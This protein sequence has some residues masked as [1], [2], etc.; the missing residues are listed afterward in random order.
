MAA[1]KKTENSPTEPAPEF[2]KK[3]MFGE[4]S[5]SFSF[6][7]H[8]QGSL[9]SGFSAKVKAPSGTIKSAQLGGDGEG[10]IAIKYTPTEAGM[11]LLELFHAGMTI[12]KPHPFKSS[13]GVLMPP[14]WATLTQDEK[15]SVLRWIARRLDAHDFDGVVV[16]DATSSTLLIASTDTNSTRPPESDE[17][18]L[19]LIGVVAEG[20][21]EQFEALRTKIIAA[22]SDA[23]FYVV[24]SQG[25]IQDGLDICERLQGNYT[26]SHNLRAHFQPSI[27]LDGRPRTTVTIPSSGSLAEAATDARRAVAAKVGHRTGAM[28]HLEIA[29]IA[30]RWMHARCQKLPQLVSGVQLEGFGPAS[31]R[32]ALVDGMANTT[33]IEGSALTLD[34]VLWYTSKAQGELHMRRRAVQAVDEPPVVQIEREAIITT[35]YQVGRMQQV[36]WL[37][38]VEAFFKSSVPKGLSALLSD[39]TQPDKKMAHR[40]RTHD[41]RRGQ[42]QLAQRPRIDF[43]PSFLSDAEVDHLLH[44]GLLH[45]KPSDSNSDDNELTHGGGAIVQFQPS[46]AT[47]DAIVQAVEERIAEATGVPVHDGE[48]AL[49]MRHN[50]PIKSNGPVVDSVHLDTN[51]DK[52][53]RCATVI[54]YLNDVPEGCGGETRFPLADLPEE[55]PLVAAAVEAATIGL[56]AIKSDVQNMPAHFAMLQEAACKDECPVKCAHSAAPPLPFG[57][58]P[59]RAPSMVTRGTMGRACSTVAAGK[60]IAQKFKEF[61]RDHPAYEAVAALGP[62]PIDDADPS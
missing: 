12:G 28:A 34:G 53:F 52:R 50:V 54:I 41:W 2:A 46:L 31:I 1:G 42:E 21:G 22:I 33:A 44:L 7:S 24:E 60:W 26:R 43:Y 9:M 37:A 17:A 48:S 27:T 51:N 6:G 19:I 18:Q 25:V 56:T 4:V 40:A 58:R 49:M 38:S 14:M 61:P 10:K 30:E 45:A 62:A 57:R 20:K 32:G 11:H 47:D 3:M 15:L 16:V 8:L 36:R 55:S 13:N 35:Q 5:M 23:K 59:T 29:A 39:P